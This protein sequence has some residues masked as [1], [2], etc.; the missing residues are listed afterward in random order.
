MM[1]GVVPD[2][3]GSG[4]FNMPNY[5]V[6]QYIQDLEIEGIGDYV[7]PVTPPR[8]WLTYNGY[9][10]EILDLTSVGMSYAWTVYS[11]VDTLTTTTIAIA[12]GNAQSYNSALNEVTTLIDS[13]P[14]NNPDDPFESDENL[15]DD[16]FEI[17]PILP[18]IDIVDFDDLRPDNIGGGSGSSSLINLSAP[19]GAP[20]AYLGLGVIF[21]A[22][23]SYFKVK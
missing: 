7:P 5:V 19:T 16:P 1:V 8:N 9:F 20:F 2:S 23:G 12:T 4:L 11:Q 3:Y 14:V 18:P 17:G 22:V 13:L 6:P 10:Y 21:L 15:G